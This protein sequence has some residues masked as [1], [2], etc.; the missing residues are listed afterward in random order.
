MANDFRE[1][2]KVPPFQHHDVPTLTKLQ[3][4]IDQQLSRAQFS[5]AFTHLQPWGKRRAL[6]VLIV[7]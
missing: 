2:I 3:C 1:L 7:F 5:A 6:V 4:E